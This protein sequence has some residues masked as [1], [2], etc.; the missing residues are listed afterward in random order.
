M[1]HREKVWDMITN[2]YEVRTQW[3]EMEL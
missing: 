1:V 3:S 2:L